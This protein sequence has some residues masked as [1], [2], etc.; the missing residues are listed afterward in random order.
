[1]VGHEPT[2]NGK[3][4]ENIRRVDVSRWKNK[5]KE[6]QAAGLSAIGGWLVG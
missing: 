3:N 6:L 2:K 4:K 5:K 1:M